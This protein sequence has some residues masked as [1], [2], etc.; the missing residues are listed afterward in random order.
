MQQEQSRSICTVAGPLRQ[1][2]PY[3]ICHKRPHPCKNNHVRDQE[4][5]PLPAIGLSAE[6]RLASPRR[7]SPPRQWT[8]QT[9]SPVS[10]LMGV[11]GFMRPHPGSFCGYPCRE[12][13]ENGQPD[14]PCLSASP[15]G[16]GM[17]QRDTPACLNEQRSS[18]YYWRMFLSSIK[19]V[20]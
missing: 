16:L 20:T 5:R 17:G 6:N 9:R 12:A 19:P 14:H 18:W 7:L 13:S 11:P 15:P 10:L 8:S 2:Q 4:R 1:Q 3:L